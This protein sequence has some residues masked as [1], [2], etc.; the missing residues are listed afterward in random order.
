[1]PQ[2][3]NRDAPDRGITMIEPIE[4]RTDC[5][6]IL[7]ETAKGLFI[8]VKE[9]RVALMQRLNES[10]VIAAACPINGECT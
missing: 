7:P 6:S 10:L 5:G 2:D 4:R 1:M 3:L 9:M 8:A